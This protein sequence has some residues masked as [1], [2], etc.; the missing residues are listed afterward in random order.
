[1]FMVLL[2]PVLTVVF[3]FSLS[4][5]VLSFSDLDEVLSEG[6]SLDDVSSSVFPLDSLSLSETG[7]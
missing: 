1:M 2:S 5:E 4:F 6:V 7:F 3:G